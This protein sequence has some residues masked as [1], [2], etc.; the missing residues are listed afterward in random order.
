[1]YNDPERRDDTSASNALND[2]LCPGRFFA[3]EGLPDTKSEWSET[4]SRIHAALAVGSADGLTLAE[5]ETFEACRKI[6]AKVLEQF[7][8]AEIAKLKVW[9]E[10]RYWVPFKDGD[11][12]WEHSG[13]CD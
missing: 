3:Q 8:G 2:A 13:K 1:M 7:F 9:R 6:E 4:G 11:L 5:S 12:E 10:Q